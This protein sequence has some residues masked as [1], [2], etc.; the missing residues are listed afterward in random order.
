V[1]AGLIE[2]SPIIIAWM[3]AGN[4]RKRIKHKS[5]GAVIIMPNLSVFL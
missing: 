1:L 5:P 2:Y 3:T 4:A